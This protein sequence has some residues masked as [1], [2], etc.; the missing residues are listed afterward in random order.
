MYIHDYLYSICINCTHYLVEKV[1]F[2]D[3]PD[4]PQHQPFLTL[5]IEQ[6]VIKKTTCNCKII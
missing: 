5:T 6:K 1:E 2:D 4:Q 3:L